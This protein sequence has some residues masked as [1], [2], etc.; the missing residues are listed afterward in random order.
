MCN[1]DFTVENPAFIRQMFAIQGG[2][3]VSVCSQSPAENLVKDVLLAQRSLSRIVAILRKER[4]ASSPN[5]KRSEPSDCFSILYY[6]S[7][8]YHG[9]ITRNE[10]SVKAAIRFRHMSLYLGADVYIDRLFGAC[11]STLGICR[12]M[13][14]V[15]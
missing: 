10:S 13:N 15:E 1:F 6:T 12:F 2:C 9:D 5:A 8:H 3:E 11:F 7:A 4:P 14:F